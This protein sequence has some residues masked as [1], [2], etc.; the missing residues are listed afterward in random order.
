ML[1][2]YTLFDIQREGA[3]SL[4]KAKE[5]YRMK[6][7]KREEEKWKRRRRSQLTMTVPT[8]FGCSVQKYGYSPASVNVCSNVAPVDNRPESN[9]PF[10]SPFSPDVTVCCAMS[11][12]V[13]VII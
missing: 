13:H 12:L 4:A 5:G 9:S 7:K 3:N 10:G 1:L 11:L 6:T 8:I 2:F